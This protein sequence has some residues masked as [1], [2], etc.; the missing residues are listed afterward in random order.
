MCTI[1]KSRPAYTNK[2]AQTWD[3]DGTT[4]RSTCSG[5]GL[6]MDWDLHESGQYEAQPN[7]QHREATKIGAYLCRWGVLAESDGGGRHHGVVDSIE[8]GPLNHACKRRTT[9]VRTHG[10]GRAHGGVG[11]GRGRASWT[12]IVLG[13]GKS[14]RTDVIEGDEAHRDSENADKEHLSRIQLDESKVSPARDG[15]AQLA[16][17]LRGRHALCRRQTRR[18]GMPERRPP[19]LRSGDQCSDSPRQDGEH[20]DPNHREVD[21]EDA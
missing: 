18:H 5:Q 4:G 7:G 10:A 21:A 20:E 15:T 11:V 2:R 16:L 13:G 19:S 8:H 14:R 9:S 1:E 3:R 17:Q 6:P 12:H